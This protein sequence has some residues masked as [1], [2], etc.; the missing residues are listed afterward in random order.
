VGGSAQIKATKQ[1]AG[2]LRLDL[3]QYWEIEAFSQFGSDLDKATLS[4]LDRGKRLIQILKQG[5]Y[6]PLRISLQIAIVY[7]TINGF[8]DTVPV[9]K[10]GEFEK[11]LQS[12]LTIQNADLLDE[13]ESVKNLTK[14]IKGKLDSIIKEILPL[15]TE[16]K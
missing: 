10:V 9:K 11:E 5:Q 14:E 7:S 12:V 16:K 1:V 13:I 2:Q 15:F 3:S 8:L 6:E 4:Q